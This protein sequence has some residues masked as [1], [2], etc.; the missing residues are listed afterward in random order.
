MIKVSAPRAEGFRG[1][2]FLNKFLSKNPGDD[3]DVERDDVFAGYIQHTLQ[4]PC[5][6]LACLRPGSWAGAHPTLRRCSW[7]PLPSSWWG[8]WAWGRWWW[9]LW[10]CGWVCF[11]IL[12]L[13][14]FLHSLWCV[15]EGALSWGLGLMSLKS[16]FYSQCQSSSIAA[17][18]AADT[19]GQT[20]A[21][22][23][24][25]LVKNTIQSMTWV[26]SCLREIRRMI[27]S[28]HRMPW[29]KCS[30]M[31]WGL[32]LIC[33][34]EA[35]LGISCKFWHQSPLTTRIS[36]ASSWELGLGPS[37]GKLVPNPKVC[38]LLNFKS[39]NWSSI[40]FLGFLFSRG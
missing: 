9:W 40:G 32:S 38:P 17:S 39:T 16:C 20:C 21:G 36:T 28:L 5:A 27:H 37:T 31:C 11:A 7:W 34:G 10:W 1:T 29:V 23:E 6:Q 15:A 14:V 24:S 3:P 4:Q 19:S 35:P 22:K 2:S 25:M 33:T 8:L 30:C 12:C 13:P 18:S 26:F